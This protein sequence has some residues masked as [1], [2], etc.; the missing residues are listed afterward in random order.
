MDTIAPYRGGAEAIGIRALDVLGNAK[1]DEFAK[2]G[3]GMRRL[4]ESTVSAYMAALR[5][6][7]AFI[8]LLASAHVERC[9]LQAWDDD[10]QLQPARAVLKI[11]ALHVAAHSLVRD[12]ERTF[13]ELCRRCARADAGMGRLMAMACVPFVPA[14]PGE[15]VI[16]HSH[17]LMDSCGVLWG[18]KCGAY[19]STA[20]RLLRLAC[21]RKPS[22]FGAQAIRRFGRGAQADARQGDLFLGVPVPA[23][24]PALPP[25][26]A[27]DQPGLTADVATRREHVANF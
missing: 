3:A 6:N 19:A 17:V 5:H 16:H 21:P 24:A 15:G 26:R 11:P 10:E 7:L 13:C 9:R 22:R 14:A 23:K 18:S 25:Q 8:S 27:G 2:F 1:A 12:G 20:P 4:P